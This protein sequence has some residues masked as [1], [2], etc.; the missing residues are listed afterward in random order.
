MAT[1]TAK[2]K[3]ELQRIG[4][5]LRHGTSCLFDDTGGD[6]DKAR[7][8]KAR[9]IVRICARRVATGRACNCPVGAARADAADRESTD[10]WDFLRSQGYIE[11][12]YIAIGE[13]PHNPQGE[14][15]KTRNDGTEVMVCRP[16]S[17]LLHYFTRYY[18]HVLAE[19]ELRAAKAVLEEAAA[20]WE[21]TRYEWAASQGYAASERE[22]AKAIA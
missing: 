4:G 6:E 22:A 14:G 12:D 18:A 20:L 7:G 2:Y 10:A 1:V 11:T 3:E 17:K 8:F 19:N 9:M 15:L 16:T 13:F 5:L 21:T